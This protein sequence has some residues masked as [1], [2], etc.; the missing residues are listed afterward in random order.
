MLFLIFTIR[1]HWKVR[2]IELVKVIKANVLE[3]LKKRINTLVTKVKPKLYLE[4][5]NN[6]SMASRKTQ[7]FCLFVL[8]TSRKFG[9]K[10][11]SNC[12]A[13]RRTEGGLEER[14]NFAVAHIPYRRTF[15]PS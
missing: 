10:T 2:V 15:R 8:L 13:I 7:F 6:K 4:D 11:E 3:R 1:F 9:G 14:H 5:I 12:R